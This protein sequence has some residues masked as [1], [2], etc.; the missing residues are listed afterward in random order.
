MP[1]PRLVLKKGKERSLLRYHRWIFSGAIDKLPTDLKDGDFVEVYGFDGNYLATGYYQDGNIAVRI[2]NFSLCD[3]SQEFWN[4][5]IIYA[6][7]LRKKLGYFSD[8]ASNCCRL[9]NAEGDQVPGLIIDLY[10]GTAIIQTH[11]AG[12]RNSL[13]E[14][15]NAL[16]LALGDLLKAVYH[17]PSYHDK[18]D[19]PGEYLFGNQSSDPVI[20]ENGLF[21][22]VDWES[23]QKTGYFLDQKDNRLILRKYCRGAK[24]LD[25]FCYAGGFAANALQGEA[26]KVDAVDISPHAAGLA[27]KNLIKNGFKGNFSVITSDV[28]K[29]LLT[30]EADHDVI[31]L[32]P[33]A[34]AKHLSARHRAV[35]GYKRLNKVAISRIRKGGIL[36]T[37]SCSQVV[38]KILFEKTIVS[39]AI[40]AGRMARILCRLGQPADHPVNI[41][42]PESEYLKGLVIEI[43]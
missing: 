40:E 20:R 8:P 33:P 21:F 22:N 9:V 41:F 12:I 4:A 30:A 31:I 15:N 18:S 5:R 35:Q 43:G 23:G 14:I 28:L 24:V 6:V 16:K 1:Y 32:D 7:E 39:A 3:I 17:R 13:N 34:F 37:F 2:L 19:N 10:D 38:D 29:Y 26:E 42:H 11:S 27:E 25:A 36:F